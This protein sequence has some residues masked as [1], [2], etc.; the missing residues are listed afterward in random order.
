MLI[1]RSTTGMTGW[2]IIPVDYEFVSGRHF[3]T[4]ATD[5]GRG[6]CVAH[7]DLRTAYDEV[8][9]Q[10]EIILSQNHQFEA[11]GHVKGVGGFRQFQDVLSA[12]S[13][14]SEHAKTAEIGW[15]APGLQQLVL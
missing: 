10:L 6:L 15:T 9:R 5:L 1:G 7:S 8:G 13:G 12:T 2:P 14:Q 11:T 3:F 4:A